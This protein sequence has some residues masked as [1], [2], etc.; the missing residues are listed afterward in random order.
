MSGTDLGTYHV[1]VEFADGRGFIN[2]WNTGARYARGGP[3]IHPLTAERVPPGWE[4]EAEL[5]KTIVYMFTEGNFSC[6]CNLL[7]FLDY[8][9][10]KEPPDDPSHHP[11]GGTL[12]R[13]RL[14]MLRPDGS[15]KVIFETKEET[16]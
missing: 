4:N 11:C 3:G 10:G 8:A 7:D 12:V 6:D 2:D 9:E 16:K 5:E 15:E 14:T 1:R 13:R